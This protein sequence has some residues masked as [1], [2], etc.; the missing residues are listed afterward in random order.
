MGEY[1]LGDFV[2][3]FR[4]GSLVMKL[5]D[6]E[7]ARLPTLLYGTING[8]IGVIAS[9]PRSQYIYLQRL[10]V[11][12]SLTPIPPYSTADLSMSYTSRSASQSHVVETESFA[13]PVVVLCSDLIV[14]TCRK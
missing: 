2:N 13:M 9:L 10:Q 6:S 8:V 4:S 11:C 14:L 5:A 1:H 12:T 7:T 3:R